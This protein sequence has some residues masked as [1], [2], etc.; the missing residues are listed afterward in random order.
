MV[1]IGGGVKE[2]LTDGERC[3]PGG[4]FEVD[5][6]GSEGEGD[7]LRG[8]ARSGLGFEAFFQVGVPGFEVIDPGFDGE[9]P[10]SQLIHGEGGLPEVVGEGG[11]GCGV[12][13]FFG[14]VAV[15]EA[16]GDVVVAVG[17]DGGG[18]GD[19]V[20]EDALCGI[21]AAVNLRL[22]LLDDDATAAF[23]R[24]HGT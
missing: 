23:D 12:P 15:E 6:S 9:E 17:E 5:G 20:V 7:V 16:T 4:L 11:E 18:D 10:V 21:A 1:E 8:G 14:G 2:D 13:V 3:A 24:F 19:L 22:D